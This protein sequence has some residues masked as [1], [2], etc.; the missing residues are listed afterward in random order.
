M[1]CQKLWTWDVSAGKTSMLR[2]VIQWRSFLKHLCIQCILYFKSFKLLLGCI[3]SLFSHRSG[4][5]LSIQSNIPTKHSRLHEGCITWWPHWTVLR[6][7]L[8]WE[9]E[10]VDAW[11]LPFEHPLM[12]V[13]AGQNHVQ[14]LFGFI[15]PQLAN[16]AETDSKLFFSQ[17][18]KP[19]S[20]AGR[21][22]PMFRS[23][24]LVFFP[25]LVARSNFHSFPLIGALVVLRGQRSLVVCFMSPRQASCFDCVSMTPSTPFLKL[26]FKSINVNM[27]SMYNAYM[28]WVWQV[29]LKTYEMGRTW[30]PFLSLVSLSLTETAHQWCHACYVM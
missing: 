10:T 13:S 12:T 21:T 7:R 9:G 18:G 30:S 28:T 25:R 5:E 29:L 27:F 8:R 3:R 6:N 26:C 1:V 11:C 17:R 20:F 23:G 16:W 15:F 24:P 4:A 19:K 22:V 14:R 2:E